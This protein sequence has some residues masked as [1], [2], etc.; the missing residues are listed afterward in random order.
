MMHGSRERRWLAA[1]APVS[2]AVSGAQSGVNP[3]GSGV[4]RTNPVAVHLESAADPTDR[5]L[6]AYTTGSISVA[7]NEILWA[8]IAASQNLTSCVQPVAVSGTGITLEQVLAVTNFDTSAPARSVSLWRARPAANFTGTIAIDYGINVMTGCAWSLV[9]TQLM[10][11]SG[12][13]GAGAMQQVKGATSADATPT[14][15]AVTFNAALEFS[16]NLC[17]AFAALDTS[18]VIA[19]SGAFV[20]LGE[21]GHSTPGTRVE[22]ARLTGG[23]TWSPTWTASKCGV[24][25]V[26]VKAG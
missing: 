1:P 2:G 15:L 11:L 17:L 5:T 20:E 10:D 13:N 26:E 24:A 4:V 18:N 22:S 16:G 3:S 12:V 7:A 21:G 23:T 6:S 14:T 8:W 25:I 9:K 19:P